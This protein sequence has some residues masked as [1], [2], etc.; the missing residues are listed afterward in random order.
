MTDIPPIEYNFQANEK[1]RHR[2]IM[3]FFK[4]N[5]LTILKFFQPLMGRWDSVKSNHLSVP[6]NHGVLTTSWYK[7]EEALLALLVVKLWVPI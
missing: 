1:D 5:N 4:N 6:I 7:W 3:T 2:E